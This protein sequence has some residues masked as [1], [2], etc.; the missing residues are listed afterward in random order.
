MKIGLNTFHKTLPN[1]RLE[2]GPGLRTQLQWA[3]EFIARPNKCLGSSLL[4][5]EPKNEIQGQS[6]RHHNVL[7]IAGGRRPS[8]HPYGQQIRLLLH[9]ISLFNGLKGLWKVF[10]GLQ[11]PFKRPYKGLSK[12]F[13]KP[14]E[15]LSK[16]FWGEIWSEVTVLPKSSPHQVLENFVVLYYSEVGLVRPLWA[17]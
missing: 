4:W 7:S 13:K 1:E 12:A 8:Q 15:G 17:L 3:I 5:R 10:K 6:Q 2:Q 11:K 16:A 14:F 9:K